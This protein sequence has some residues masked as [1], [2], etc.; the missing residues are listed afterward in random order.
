MA[1]PC[2]TTWGGF[3]VPGT[4]CL[5]VFYDTPIQGRIQ[6]AGACA[7]SKAPSNFFTN[8]QHRRVLFYKFTHITV[9]LLA[10]L[11]HAAIVDHFT[12]SEPADC[13]RFEF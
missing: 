12:G 8:I 11:G 3:G 10:L 1:A 2:V 4:T 7:P 13:M 5:V 9:M 6:E